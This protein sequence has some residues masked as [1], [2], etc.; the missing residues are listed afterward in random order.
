M[1][2]LLVGIVTVFSFAS[3]AFGDGIYVPER[4]V[5]KFPEIPAQR[6]VLAWKDGVETLLIASALDSEA[7]KLGW[8]IPI[9]AVPQTIEKATPGALKTLT[10]CIQPRITHDLSSAVAAIAIVVVVANLLLGAVLFECRWLLALLTVVALLFA[11]SSLVVTNT[12]GGSGGEAPARG[13]N[14]QVEKSGKV[15]AYDISVLRP[16]KPEDLN[17]WLVENGFSALPEAA[18]EAVGD[19]ISQGWVFAAIKLSRAESGQNTPH[20]IKMT[21]ATQEA[22]YPLRLTAI[23]GGNPAFEVFVIADQSAS[24]GFLKEEFCDRFSKSKRGYGDDNYE[25]HDAFRGAA[26]G[27]Q[28]GHPEIGSL[29]WDDCVLTKFAGTIHPKEMT[30]DA[31]F[32]WRSFKAFR[33]RLYTASGARDL[34]E[35][36]FLA[37][38]GVWVCVSMAVCRSRIQQPRGLRWYVGKVVLPAIALTAFGAAAAFLSVPKLP[39]SEVHFS[40]GPRDYSFGLVHEAIGSLLKTHPETLQGSEEDIADYILKHV[41]QRAQNPTPYFANPVTGTQLQAEDS[42]GNFTVEKR[43][44]TVVVRVYDPIGMVLVAKYPIPAR[45]GSASG[46]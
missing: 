23:A 22:V 35:I 21:F 40:R 45:G 27:Q 25:N 4:A 37:I 6:A 3:A 46:R 33:Q 29:M 38:A 20:P 41:G 19:Y 36:L 32:G 43:D 28:I 15:G 16:A 9:P 10:Y 13:A 30:T 44:D 11:I 1:R 26:T 18:D 31:Q 42:P 7:Q 5:R 8:L 17:A 34:A 24:C 12:F 2:L 39:A 14:V